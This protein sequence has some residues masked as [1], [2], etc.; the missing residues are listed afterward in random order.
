MTPGHSS[1]RW[2]KFGEHVKAAIA[3]TLDC[4]PAGAG[5]LDKPNSLFRMIPRAKVTSNGQD[6]CN[7]AA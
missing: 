2:P 4:R 3:F 5:L 7:E 6:D 1:S